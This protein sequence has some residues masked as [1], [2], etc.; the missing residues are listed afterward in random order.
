MIYEISIIFQNIVRSDNE[1]K[2]YD[3]KDYYFS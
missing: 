2:F 1:E 3:A